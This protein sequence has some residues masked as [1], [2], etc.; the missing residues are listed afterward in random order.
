MKPLV[1]Y[2][3]NCAD[4]FGAAWAIHHKHPDWEF[5]AGHYGQEPP[6]VTNRKVV[7]VDFSYSRDQL[8]LMLNDAKSILILDHHKS[9]EKDLEE[10]TGSHFE[11]GK[12]PESDIIAIFD[13]TES[14][15]MMAWNYFNPGEE[16]PKL[17]KHIQDRDLW[18]FKLP[19]TKEISAALFSYPYKFGVWA[20]LMSP[21]CYYTL[22]T[23]GKSIMQKQTK[24]IKELLPQVTRQMTIGDV[25]VPVANLPY[26]FASEA[27][28]ILAKDQPFAA[29]YFDTK[30][31][32]VFSLRSDAEFD[33]SFDVSEVAKCYGGGG[34]KHA[35]G[36]KVP[37]NHKLARC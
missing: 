14:G 24:D 12:L 18:Q 17:I 28:E 37:R 1:I 33:Y 25:V 35:A 27:G 2:H 19:N 30:T 10:F 3:G 8:L 4:G 20:E 7:L 32:R 29:T 21:D 6:D 26:Q 5:Y 9:T 31:E 11:L 23:E 15:A 22:I 16:P 36:F 34:H 13:M